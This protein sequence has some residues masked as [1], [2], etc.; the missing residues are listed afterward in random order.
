MIADDATEAACLVCDRD[1]TWATQLKAMLRDA[2]VAVRHC[3]SLDACWQLL[4]ESPASIV[5]LVGNTSNLDRVF[6][7]LCRIRARFTDARALVVLPRGYTEQAWWLREAG[8]S[9]VVHSIRELDSVVRIVL[10]HRART[11]VVEE[12]LSD[13]MARRLPW[14]P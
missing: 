12:T 8:A 6:G 13:R 2:G 1:H 7:A 3:V 14:G 11:T 5:L 10:R 9:H 4:E